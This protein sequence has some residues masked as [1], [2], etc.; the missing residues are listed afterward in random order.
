MQFDMQRATRGEHDDAVVGLVRPSELRERA[1][2]V[3]LKP[4]V[5]RRLSTTCSALGNGDA[6]TEPFQYLECRNSNV[7]IELI[8]KARDEESDVG[9]AIRS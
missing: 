5:R 9:H 8:Y 7:R 2:S 4:G 1:I 6:K 3:V